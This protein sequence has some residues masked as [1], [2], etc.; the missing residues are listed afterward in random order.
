MSKKNRLP[1]K[2]VE[3]ITMVTRI[4]IKGTN[5][6]LSDILSK[7]QIRFST[8]KA[9]NEVRVRRLCTH[10]RSIIIVIYMYTRLVIS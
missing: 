8:I 9:P 7:I 10:E 2:C 3:A 4:R 5:V 1:A 6:K